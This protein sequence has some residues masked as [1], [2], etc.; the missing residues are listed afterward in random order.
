MPTPP[1]APR[2][3][4]RPPQFPPPQF[5]PH[6]PKL[7][8]ATPPAIFP[9]IL[10]LIGAVLALRAARQVADLPALAPFVELLAGA[11][12]AL[13]AFAVVA[14]KAKVLRRPG[15]LVQDMRPL[16]GRGGLAAAAMSGM[17]AGALIAP[18]SPTVA[19]VLILASVLAHAILLGALVVS[20]RGQPAEMRV[21]N[22][23][24]HQSVVGFIVAGAPLA[25]LGWTG[26]ATA[27]FWPTLA[28]ALVIWA[29]SAR[30]ALAHLP[31][32]PLR[33]LMAIH[34]APAALLSLTAAALGMPTLSTA[35]AAVAI[36]LAVALLARLRWITEAGFT[37]MWGA[38]TFPLAAFALALIGQGGPLALLGAVLALLALVVN[39]LIAW[40]VLRLW[41]G[42]R[43]AQKTNAAEA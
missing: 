1:K 14:L 35:L 43:L 20:L 9:P 28:A 42:N 40:N 31:P 37:P 16:P 25:R 4:R 18:Y 15:V 41:P 24:L 33:P 26:T 7:F 32:P 38:F 39:G 27:I 8:A 2:I 5:P 11:V 29:L 17:A 13:W 22:P 21:V 6:R 30:D 3:D 36:A 10:G 19:T 12:L 34:L 23:T